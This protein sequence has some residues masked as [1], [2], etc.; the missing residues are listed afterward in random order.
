MPG[1][2]RRVVECDRWKNA[3]ISS[4]A[5]HQTILYNYDNTQVCTKSL[6]NKGVY[7]KII[8]YILGKTGA[9]QGTVL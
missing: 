4:G 3:G 2:V 5:R 8:R 9:R 7:C 1:A 6:N